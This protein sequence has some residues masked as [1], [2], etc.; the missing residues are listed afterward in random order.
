M[1]EKIIKSKEVK[2]FSMKS[3]LIK[4][5]DIKA[6]NEK[7][8]PALKQEIFAPLIRGDNVELFESAEI[9]LVRNWSKPSLDTEIIMF[10]A[11]YAKKNAAAS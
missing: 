4:K 9:D 3:L 7:N 1:L 2:W 11:A 5:N 6:I 8:T 10:D